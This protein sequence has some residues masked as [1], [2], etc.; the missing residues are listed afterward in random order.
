MITIEDAAELRLRQPHVVRLESRPPSVEGRG[1]V[2]IRD[3]LRNALRM[4]PDRI[5]I[6]EVRG[7]EALDLLTALNTGHDGALSTV[8]ANSPADALRRL[9]TLA[10]MAG[11]GLPHDAIREQVRRGIELVVHLARSPQGERRVVEVGEVVAG[12]RWGRR[13]GA[14]APMTRRRR[15]AVPVVLGAPRRA[16]W[17]RW[18]R[19]RP[20]LATPALG[21]W[22]ADAVEP[23]LRAG[24][25]GYAPTEAERRRLAALGNRRAAC[26]A[27]CWSS[28]PAPRRLRRRWPAPAPR[29]GRWPRRRA[30]YRRA[31]ERGLPQVATAVADALAG[32]S[33]V[34]AAL[35]SAASSVEGPPAAELARAARRPRAGGLHRRRRLPRFKARLRSAAGRLVRRGASLPAARR[36]RSRRASATLRRLLGGARS[37]RRRRPLGHRAGALHRA[38]GGRHAGG[39]RPV[40]RADR[41]RLRRRRCSPTAASAALLAV[42]GGAS[43]WAAS[44]RSGGSQPDRGRMSVEPRGARSALA[45]LLGAAALWE[46]AGSRGEELGRLDARRRWRRSAAGRARSL[47]GAALWLRLPQRLRARR[48]GRER[49]GRRSCS[50]GKVAG[51]RGGRP[52]RGGRLPRRCPAGWRSWSPSRCPR[53]D[54]WPR[55]RC[56]S[57]RRDAAARRLVAALPEALDLLAVGT[58]AGRSPATVL[59]E[60]STGAGGPLACELAVAVAEIECGVPQREAIAA[61]RERVPAARGSGRWRRRSSARA[62][63]ARRWPTSSTSRRCRCGARRG[64]RI[65][66]RAARAAPKI[67]LVVALVLGPVGP[68]DDPRRADR[69]LGRPSRARLAAPRAATRLADP[70]PARR[71]RRRPLER[72]Q[73]ASTSRFRRHPDHG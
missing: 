54:S 3:L 8:H 73:T 61:L 70:A 48:A 69:P 21:R 59:G 50:A 35:A 4:R 28:D 30:R 31:V 62:G 19:A 26:S 47:A 6:G 55:R 12:G 13:P 9:E 57:G 5:V 32:G 42:G 24:R 67:Q 7:R 17:P 71:A 40:R 49:A 18:R 65:E 37:G 11:V 56:W 29:P 15:S 52:A 22:L 20:S 1:E 36:R 16:G 43:S 44:P 34:R 60:I 63:S 66:E 72:R 64:A 39:S 68:A 2:T 38:A 14:V 53:R 33:S 27:G 10:L 46:L 41:A 25:E 23:L 51:A 58:A 45:V